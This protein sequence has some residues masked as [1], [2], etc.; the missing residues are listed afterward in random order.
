MS[1][2]A[3]PPQ[4]SVASMPL[5]AALLPRSTAACS[6]LTVV[7]SAESTNAL[8]RAGIERAPADWPH[9]AALITDDQ[10]AGRGR[11]GRHWVA[12]PGAALALSVVLDVSEL[13]PAALGWLPLL[14]GVAAARSID[15]QLGA[16][17]GRSAH[18]HTVRLKWPNDVLVDGR[19]ICGILCEL[20]PHGRVIVGIGINTRMPQ[21]EPPV[22]TATSFSVLGAQAADDALIAGVITALRQLADALT[23]SGGD[24]ARSGVRGE[25]EALCAT[26]G[27]RVRV[28]LPGRG[29][30]DS[31][32]ASGEQSNGEYLEGLATALGDGGEL[33]V[34]TGARLVSCSAGDVTHVRAG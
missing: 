6:R 33:I 15:A 14:A 29:Q 30:P 5:D 9:G 19:K 4:A 23:L 17:G 31:R 7:P 22:P 20:T 26:L 13:P 12:A 3:S 25:V 11:L 34:D 32:Q 16:N 10:R 8:V 18:E 24:A 27:T 28:E 21:H 1:H 2:A